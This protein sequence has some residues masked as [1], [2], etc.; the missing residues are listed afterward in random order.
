MAAY[1]IPE[2]IRYSEITFPVF[3]SRVW[4]LIW[5]F[6]ESPQWRTATRLVPP[7]YPAS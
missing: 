6:C 2:S 4:M 3:G 1:W 7:P 5:P